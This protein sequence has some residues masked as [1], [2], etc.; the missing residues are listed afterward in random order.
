MMPRRDDKS[1]IT[2]P[3]YSSGVSTSTAIIGSSNT[4]SALR[5][6]SLKPIEAAILNAFSF[7]STSWYE[8]S[9]NVTFTST[10]GKPAKIPA[11]IVSRR[12]L[13]TAGI[14]SRGTVPPLMASTNS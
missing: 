13:S 6:P 9:N 12:P 5:I 4:G 14:N 11:G 8:P 2:S 1:P 10:T 7:E 3:M